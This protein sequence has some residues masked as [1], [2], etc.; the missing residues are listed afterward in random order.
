MGK[1]SEALTYGL[2]IRES[3][4]D[5]SDFTNPAADYRRLFLGEDGQL[6][7]K[8]SAGTVTDIGSGTSASGPMSLAVGGTIVAPGAVS[9]WTAYNL[10]TASGAD[11]TGGI[12]LTGMADDFQLH[13]YERAAPGST[14]WTLTACLAGYFAQQNYTTASIFA[15]DSGGTKAV[16]F[17]IQ[18]VSGWTNYVQYWNSSSSFGSDSTSIAAPFNGMFAFLKL[19]DNGTNLVYSYSPNGLD[20]IQVYS[21]SRTAHLAAGPD[22]IGFS[23][24][25]NGASASNA[26]RVISW[27]IT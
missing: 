3:A 1:I 20:Y 22:L 18:W 27:E 19:T 16:N 5:G 25:R 4:D 10:G 7:V 13:G 11:Y 21:A 9:T 17:T 14:P 15:R 26:L 2:T 8:D 12:L 6:H 24:F 23:M